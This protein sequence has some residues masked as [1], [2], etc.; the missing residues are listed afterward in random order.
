LPA[1]AGVSRIDPALDLDVILND[2]RETSA[3]LALS[4]SLAFGGLNA[5]LALRSME[6][7]LKR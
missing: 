6:P 1:N 3:G 7:A 5:V 2:S 4:N